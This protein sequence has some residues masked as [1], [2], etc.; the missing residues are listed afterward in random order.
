MSRYQVMP[1][2]E[3]LKIAEIHINQEISD[4]INESKE[5]HGVVIPEYWRLI[6]ES[7]SELISV[8]EHGDYRG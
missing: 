7:I 5:L 2:R 4:L 1:M 8:Q 3:K 6:Q